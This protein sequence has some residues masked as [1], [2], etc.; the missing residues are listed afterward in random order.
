MVHYYGYSYL[1][2]VVPTRTI[3]SRHD[4]EH[5][6]ISLF[7]FSAYQ[8]RLYSHARDS[9]IND[10]WFTVEVTGWS[11]ARILISTALN[12]HRVSAGTLTI[13][14]LPLRVV[15]DLRTGRLVHLLN[16]AANRP[17]QQMP[18]RKEGTTFACTRMWT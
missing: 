4:H 10:R 12:L 18:K 15:G 13:D 17:A 2:V 14:R 6:M 3:H 11:Y 9:E 16:L 7:T 5:E 8:L 1:V